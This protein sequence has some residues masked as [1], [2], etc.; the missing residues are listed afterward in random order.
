VKVELGDRDLKNRELRVQ[1][2]KRVR[3]EEGREDR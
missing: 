3:G 2:M 1:G